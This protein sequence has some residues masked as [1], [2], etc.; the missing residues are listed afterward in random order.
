MHRLLIAILAVL[1]FFPADA[2]KIKTKLP[3]TKTDSRLERM[4]QESIAITADSAKDETNYKISDIRFSGYD[5]KAT[6]DKE[7]FFVTNTTDRTLQGF[8][9]YIIYSTV[10]GKQLHRRYENVECNAAPG[11]TVKID[12][13]SWDSQKS[14]YYEKSDAP[15]GS[16]RATPYTIAF[17]PVAVYLAY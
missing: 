15:R 12:I 10:A 13:K 17:E 7:T 1:A 5:K 11:E 16:R 8:S 9:I 3:L 2:R 14:F 4:K 6:A